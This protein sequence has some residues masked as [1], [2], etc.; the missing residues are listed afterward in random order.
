MA[1]LQNFFRSQGKSRFQLND[2]GSNLAEADIRQPDH[3]DI[4]DRVMFPQVIFDLDRIKVLAAGNDH[5]FLTVNEV[6]ET[7]FGLL[8]HIAGEKPAVRQHL[9]RGFSSL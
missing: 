9:F 1:E 6:N 2:C 4:L 7:V 5:I 8:C 3:S